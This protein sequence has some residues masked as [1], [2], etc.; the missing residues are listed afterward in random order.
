[1][2]LID[3]SVWIF[4]LRSKA[5]QQIQDAVAK[6][7]DSGE[8]VASCGLINL[9]LLAG[10]KSEKEFT[11]LADL[12][13]ALEYLETNAQLWLAASRLG[14]RLQRKGVSVPT[15]DLVIASL[16]IEHGARLIHV[17]RHFVMIAQHSELESVDY[18]E[19]LKAR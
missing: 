2:V 14:F 7:L 11:R 4:A 8:G 6:L 3:S 10:T 19:F 13:F 16:G 9:E 15:S 18:S 12:L 17:D 5:N 1:M